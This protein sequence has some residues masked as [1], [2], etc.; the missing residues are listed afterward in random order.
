MKLPDDPQ[1]AVAYLN[2]EVELLKISLDSKIQ[3]PYAKRYTA[4]GVIKDGMICWA[5]GTSWNPGSGEGIY[6]YRSGAW[7]F[8]G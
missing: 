2:R 3:S 1:S 7:H 8:L 5:D 4:P 6:Q